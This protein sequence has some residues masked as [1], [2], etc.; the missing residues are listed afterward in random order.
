[1]VFNRSFKLANFAVFCFLSCSLISLLSFI[2]PF[3]PLFT[4]AGT[5]FKAK[6]ILHF[7][8]FLLYYL[9]GADAHFN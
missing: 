8:R 5:V 2:L 6:S 9:V 3:S 1:M 4:R 7:T